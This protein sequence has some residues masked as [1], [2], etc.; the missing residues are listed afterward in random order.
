V[1]LDVPFE[2]SIPRGAA[3]GY[4]H[5]DPG[6]PSNQRYVEGQR[7]YLAECDP[8]AR[9]TMVLDNTDLDRPTIR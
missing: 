1:F 9:A 7:R 8:R 3:R 2:V 5:P 6:H 4:G